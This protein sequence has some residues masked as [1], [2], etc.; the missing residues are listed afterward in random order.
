MALGEKTV[1][2]R[3]RKRG[4]AEKKRGMVVFLADPPSYGGCTEDTGRI[5]NSRE[6][7]RWCGLESGEEVERRRRGFKGKVGV[8]AE[9]TQLFSSLV[10]IRVVSLLTRVV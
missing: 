3:E 9:W 1:A 7:E 8:N 2:R 5:A 10:L 6:R 4:T